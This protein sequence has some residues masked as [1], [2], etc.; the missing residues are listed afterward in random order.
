MH[1]VGHSKDIFHV[2]LSTECTDVHVTQQQCVSVCVAISFILAASL[3]LSVYL[4]APAGFIQ[5]E[6]KHTGFFFLHLPFAVHPK[7]VDK[8]L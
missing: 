4:C 7:Y 6:G 1:E 3:H 8:E 2:S 5:E